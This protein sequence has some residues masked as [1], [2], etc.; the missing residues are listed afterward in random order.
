MHQ[1]RMKL[2]LVDGDRARAE[3]LARR[4][5]GPE[6]EI[7][8]AD[9]GAGA[10]LEAH[11]VRPDVIISTTNLPVLNGFLMLEG[12]RQERQTRGIPVILLTE[13]NSHEELARGWKAGADLCIP[14]GGGEND[15]V[16]TVNRALAGL[17]QYD[18]HPGGV[19]A[20]A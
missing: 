15:M 10:L 11:A 4:L 12:L 19:P 13:G 20:L 1:R 17:L 14:R 16:S 5:T 3:R 2:L 7:Q 18:D 9:N 8:F 6:W